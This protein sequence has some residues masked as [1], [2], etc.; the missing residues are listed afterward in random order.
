M[1]SSPATTSIDE[2]VSLRQSALA[3]VRRHR[4]R[5]GSARSGAGLSRRLGRGLDFAEVREYQAGDDIR[6]IDWNVTARTGRA[7]TKLFVEERERPVLLVVDSRNGMRF[8]TQGM[9]KSAMAARLAAILGWSAVGAHDRVGG[10]VFTDDWHAE[11][12]PQSGRRGLMSLFRAIVHAQQQT[13]QPGGTALADCLGRLRQSAPTGSTVAILSDFRAF[14]DAA[15]SSLGNAL[16]TLDVLAVQ[17]SDPLERSLPPAGR[18]SLT[19]AG[20]ARR[21]LVDSRPAAAR[22]LH[23]QRFSDHQAAIGRF[24]AGAR[25]HRVCVS[26]QDALTDAAHQALTARAPRAERVDH[27]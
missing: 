21:L 20:G 3:L 11:I 25:H 23:A 19:D 5:S 18:Y 1:F 10:Y 6:Q 22:A 14:D 12:R 27:D 2:L 17:I 4:L 9:F 15:R 7:H 8:G 16:H 24:F 13:P 26:T